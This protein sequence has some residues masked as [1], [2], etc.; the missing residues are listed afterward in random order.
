MDVRDGV[1]NR[2]LGV[3]RIISTKIMAN[4]TALAVT[5]ALLLS[6]RPRRFMS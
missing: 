3:A 6:A 1:V 4:R 5:G 2:V